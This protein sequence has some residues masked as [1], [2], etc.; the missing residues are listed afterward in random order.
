MNKKGVSVKQILYTVY[1]LL[2]TL[3]LVTA[4]N[5]ISS[6][7]DESEFSKDYDARDL[8]LLLDATYMAQGRVMINYEPIGNYRYEIEDG[9]VRLYKKN[10]LI[11]SAYRYIDNNFLEDI[12]FISEEEKGGVVISKDEKGMVINY[13]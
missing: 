5:Y 8:A 10:D 4:I 3:F 11:S 2:A 12:K 7:R 9:F 1:V 6:F 13:V